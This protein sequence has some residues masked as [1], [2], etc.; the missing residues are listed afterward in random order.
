MNRDQT[1][2]AI[3]AAV[4]A[5]LVGAAWWWD[6]NY[7]APARLERQYL[8]AQQAIRT[9][10][11]DFFRAQQECKAQ[12][13]EFGGEL[14]RSCFEDLRIDQQMAAL[15]TETAERDIAKLE[16]KHCPGQTWCPKRSGLMP[17]EMDWGTESKS[18]EIDKFLTEKP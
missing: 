16:E 13:I 5:G 15:T 10:R 6:T 12:V 11:A 18:S 14:A 7:A 1:V 17:W 9:A 2:L 3:T 4:I 8:E